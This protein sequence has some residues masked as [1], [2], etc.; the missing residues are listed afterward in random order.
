MAPLTPY[1][2]PGKPWQRIHIDYAEKEGKNFLIV[3]DAY[4]KWPEI[5]HMTSTTATATIR[6]MREIFARNGLPLQ[7]VSDNGPQFASEE[8]QTFLKQNGVKSCLT[9]PY[10]P[11]S[12]GAAERMVQ[13]FKRSLV[14]SKKDGKSLEHVIANFLLVYRSTPHATT[15]RTP[16]SLFYQR[17]L[18]TRLSL[19]RPV[20]ENNVILKQS[21]QKTHHDKNSHFREFYTGESVHVKDLVRK[22]TWYPAVITQR[23]APKT[24]IVTLR[25][26]RVWQRHIDHL[27]AAKEYHTSEG[28]SGSVTQP[29]VSVSEIPRPMSEPFIISEGGSVGQQLKVSDN[30][31][32]Q[33]RVERTETVL[34]A[35]R[36]IAPRENDV[37]IRR[38]DRSKHKPQRLIE[39]M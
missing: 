21:V 35:E 8:F 18:R 11:A 29:A 10:H 7:V 24:Y 36:H 30:D 23:K 5:Y 32:P 9:S 19:V 33:Q 12:N 16:A 34:S 13:S 6:V 20:T 22:D 28:D 25:D 15:G 17:E 27:R 1:L 37:P 2:W 39:N 31:S 38:S 26:G 4:S 3:V 14:A